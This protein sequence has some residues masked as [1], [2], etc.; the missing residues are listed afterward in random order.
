MLPLH[1][2]INKSRLSLPIQV[3]GYGYGDPVAFIGAEVMLC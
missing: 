2:K 3:I 1:I